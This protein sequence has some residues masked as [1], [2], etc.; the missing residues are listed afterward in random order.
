MTTRTL[1][2]AIACVLAFGVPAAVQPSTAVT[3]AAWLHFAAAALGGEQKLR[4]LAAVRISG[5][6]AWR[7]REQSER[8]EGPWITTFTEFT[9]TRVFAANAV[10][11][12]FR[13]RGPVTIDDDAWTGDAAV[14][15]VDDVALRKDGDRLVQTPT[16]WDLGAVPLALGP[17]RVVITALDARDLR[18][19]PD[20]PLHGF[21]HHV[22][23][24]THKGARVRLFLAPTGLLPKVVEVTRERP[25]ETYWAPW[26]DVTERL[27]FGVWALEPNGV[28][29]PRLWELTTGDAEDGTI[30]VTRVAF[31]PPVDRADFAVPDDVRSTAIANRR[32]IADLPLGSQQRPAVEL[33]PGIVK[34]PANFDILEVR[35]DDGVVIVEGPLTSAYS[36]KAIADARVRF[37]ASVGLEAAITTSDAWPHVGGMRE[38]VARGVPIYALDLNAPLLTRLFAAPY[39]TSPDALARAPRAP[40]LRRVTGKTVVGSGPNRLELYPIR[41]ATTERQIM[42]YFPEHRLLYTSDAFTIRGT[43][44]FLPQ[45]VSEVVDAVA[46][47]HL[48]VATA[49]G[50]H[51]DALPWSAVVAAAAPGADHK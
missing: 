19:E 12:T 27:T 28:R 51:Y 3:A 32:R 10:R 1:G 16:P 2:A 48:S 15:V 33:A 24:F 37:G 43:F 47:E 18:A 7:G 36:A 8:P 23:S 40:V 20:A 11:R 50:M 5:V 26:G 38:Y 45:M 34:V 49:V 22:V 42:A 29:Y 13:T 9:D 46:R 6:S 44:V 31:D 17:E 4:A 35:Q 25:Y 21:A 30:D 41:G 39:V 14:L